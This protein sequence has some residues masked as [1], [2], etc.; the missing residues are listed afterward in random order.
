[1]PIFAQMLKEIETKT[2]KTIRVIQ[3]IVIALQ[4]LMQK[5]S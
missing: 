4:G 1:M 5:G 3:A 2:P